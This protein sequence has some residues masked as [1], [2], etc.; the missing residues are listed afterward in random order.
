MSE[1]LKE[2]QEICNSGGFKTVIR[3]RKVVLKF[4]ISYII[5]DT[6]GHND[7]CLHFQKNALCPCRDDHCP[8]SDLSKFGSRKSRPITMRDIVATEG[9]EERLRLISQR[10]RVKNALYPLPFADRLMGIHGCTP[11]ETLHVIDQGL[12]KYIVESLHDII[13]EKDAGRAEKDAFTKMFK[14]INEALN[15]QSE[16]DFPRRSVRFSPIDGSRITA[17]EVRGNCVVFIVCFHVKDVQLLMGNV[18]DKYNSK[19]DSSYGPTLNGCADALTDILCYE[20]WLKEENAV[21]EIIASG[22]RIS[23]ALTK[24]KRRFPRREGTQGYDLQKM[25]GA[26]KMGTIQMCKHGNASGWDSSYGERMHKFFFTSLGHNTQRRHAL[27]ATQLANRRWENFTI[28]TA[29]NHSNGHL[30]DMEDSDN[31]S[32]D[33]GGEKDGHELTQEYEWN[34]HDSNIPRYPDY[35]GRGKYTVTRYVS[36]G[37][38]GEFHLK[39]TDRDAHDSK[40][41]VCDELLFGLNGYAEANAWSDEFTFVGYTSIKKKDVTTKKDTT[42]RSDLDYRGKPWRDW[43]MFF[44]DSSP[45]DSVN[46]GLILGFGRFDTPGFPTPANKRLYPDGVPK[47]AVDYSGYIIARCSNQYQNFD[48]KF[49]T[50]VTIIAGEQSIYMIAMKDLLGPLAVV[51]NIFTEFRMDEQ[52]SWLAVMPYRKWG[53]HFGGSIKW[54]KS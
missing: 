48:K 35:K 15:R 16:R 33:D 45:K 43:A 42:Y 23:K 54:N 25:L 44:F 11:W 18:F 7:L 14:V 32:C 46:A 1:A 34:Y 19:K 50:P 13:G 3:G 4:F 30:M 2:L 9:N 22:D 20:K 8:Q 38:E 17:V 28:D 12:L 41:K 27:F 6:A 39:W 49:I 31:E 52:E 26:Y 47:D 40:K 21:G 29:V 5:G 36:D 10:Y 24:V 37:T 53:R 51:P